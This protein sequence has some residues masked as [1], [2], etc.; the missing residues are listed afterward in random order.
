MT[1]YID[2]NFSEYIADALN[3][4]D[5]GHYKDVIVASTIH[6]FGRGVKDPI[7]IPAVASENAF[8]ITRDFGRKDGLIIPLCNKHK[9]ST[10][11][12]YLKPQLDTHWY[13]V[14]TI[15]NNWEEMIDKAKNERKH[16]LYR[17]R[18]KG[19]MEKM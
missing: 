6:K 5:K 17:V 12:V 3:S 11:F 10:F 2:E 13:I 4:L 8:L 7:L 16:F 9:V 14:K 19:Q 18:S 1:F 15:I